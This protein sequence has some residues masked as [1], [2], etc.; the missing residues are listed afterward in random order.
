MFVGIIRIGQIKLEWGL[1]IP[2]LILDDGFQM[3]K[4]SSIYFP[5]LSKNIAFQKMI[6]NQIVEK[7]KR[8]SKYEKTLKILFRQV[9]PMFTELDRSIQL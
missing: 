7:V 5:S 9:G 3:S 6:W 4:S 2:E 8:K 1:M